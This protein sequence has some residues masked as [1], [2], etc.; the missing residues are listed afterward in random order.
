[1]ALQ[2]PIL[3]GAVAGLLAK[4]LISGLGPGGL[5]LRVVVGVAGALFA[6]Y[7][8]DS[9]GMY[10]YGETGGWLGAA[11]GAIVLLIIYQL[12]LETARR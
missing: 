11:L 6:T 1:M 5:L 4:I 12:V 9:I 8:G 7:M 2:W 3:I 10:A